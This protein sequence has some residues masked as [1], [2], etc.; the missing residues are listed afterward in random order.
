M[1]GGLLLLLNFVLVLMVLFLFALFA[2]MLVVLFVMI[3]GASR[4]LSL[5]IANRRRR[6]GSL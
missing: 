6:T 2:M 3:H 5:S 4:L 1:A